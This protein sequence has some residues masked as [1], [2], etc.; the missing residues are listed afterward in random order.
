MTR[1]LLAA[2]SL[3][4]L[5]L[6][7]S[8]EAAS[9][10]AAEAKDADDGDAMPSVN[11]LDTNEKEKNEG[12]IDGDEEYDYDEDPYSNGVNKSFDFFQSITY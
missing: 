1:R 8:S 4:L 3:L 11:A 9:F 10:P 2:F 7:A 6:P 12:D 5:L